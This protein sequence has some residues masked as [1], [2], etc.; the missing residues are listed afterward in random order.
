MSRFAAVYNALLSQSYSVTLCR[1]LKNTLAEG[2]LTV[3]A[4][5]KGAKVNK[6]SVES[7][8][9]RLL[10]LIRLGLV[11]IRCKIRQ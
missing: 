10:I 7:A 8:P 3:V 1:R 6:G 9:L 2:V 4:S 11:L 5:G